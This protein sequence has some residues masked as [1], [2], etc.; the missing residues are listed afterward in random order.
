MIPGFGYGGGRCMV[1]ERRRQFW[2]LLLWHQRYVF[3]CCVIYSFTQTILQYLNN[4]TLK[5]VHWALC[6]GVFG[7]R[8]VGRIECEYLDILLGVSEADLLSHHQGLVDAIM[9]LPPPSPHFTHHIPTRSHSI[10]RHQLQLPQLDP[11]NPASLDSSSSS[12][13]SSSVP[14]TLPTPDCKRQ[15]RSNPMR[16]TASSRK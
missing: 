2:V 3:F 8:D 9:Y 11:S 15:P 5:N 16:K 14:H 13:E 1:G 7:K 12:S 4:S 10:T 6:T